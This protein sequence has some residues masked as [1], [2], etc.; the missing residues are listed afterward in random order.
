MEWNGMNGRDGTGLP[1]NAMPCHATETKNREK[2]K[3]WKEGLKR[4]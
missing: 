1:C 4:Q 2:E 3:Q